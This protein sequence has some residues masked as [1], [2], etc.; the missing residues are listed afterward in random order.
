MDQD[1]TLRTHCL[2]QNELRDLVIHEHDMEI[3]SSQIRDL[4]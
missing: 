2:Y 1:P 3:I 4:I